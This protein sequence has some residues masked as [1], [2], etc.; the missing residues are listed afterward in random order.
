MKKLLGII[1]LGLF[2]SGNS[3]AVTESLYLTCPETI[4][5]D[6]SDEFLKEYHVSKGE[7]SQYWYFDIKNKK[8]KIKI[9]VYAHGYSED[10][11]W[12]EVKPELAFDSRNKD[13]KA[14]L[15]DGEYKFTTGSKEFFDEFL[16]YKLNDQ[17]KYDG[18]SVLKTKEFTKDY[19]HSGKCNMHKKKEFNKLR[20][21]GAT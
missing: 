1:V 6:N 16:I 18:R 2:L 10:K 21:E 7:I 13:T 20:K 8:S 9:K 12:H 14:Y 11:D 17:W 4:T 5:E 15:K 19:L 3:Y